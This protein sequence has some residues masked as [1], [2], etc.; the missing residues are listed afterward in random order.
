MRPTRFLIPGLLAVL[1]IVPVNAKILGRWT[2]DSGESSADLL[3]SSDV[4]KGAIISGLSFNDSFTNFGPEAVPKDLHD[5]FGFG[6]NRGDRVIFLHRATYFDSSAVPDPRPTVA[7]YTSWGIGSNQGTG[8]DLSSN[9]NAAISFTVE[10]D[11]LSIITVDSLTLDFTSGGACIWQIQ[12]AG[13]AEGAQGTLN[14]GNPLL[15]VALN[16]PVVI[17][18]GETKT[19]TINVN[20]GALN[21]FHNIDGLSLNGFR[22]PSNPIELAITKIDYAPEANTVTL[23]WRKTLATSYI[24]KYS[25]DMTG[26]EGE[27]DDDITADRDEN[28]ED[29]TQITLTIPLP[30]ILEDAPGNFFRIEIGE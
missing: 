30:V 18:A 28:P 14:P 22:S 6:G 4:A 27:L 10:A 2:F 16:T 13:A 9:G 12:E 11:E 7:D 25:L 1:P 29:V 24:A 8:A 21:S 3:A 19:F 26:W 5:G 15:T 23:T 20:S 17:G